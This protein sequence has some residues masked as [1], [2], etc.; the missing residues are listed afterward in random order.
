[1]KLIMMLAFAGALFACN[2]PANNGTTAKDS[3]EHSDSDAATTKE[4]KWVPVDSAAAMKAWM[5]F[6]TPGPVHKWLA[7]A[8]GEWEGEITQWMAPDA[9]PMTIKG[10]S[11][12]KTIMGGRYQVG[13]FKGSFMGQPFEGMS[14]MGYDNT[15]KM[16]VSSW[17]DNM[18]TGI[19]QME[20]P[21]DTTA[22]TITLT[23]S[24]IDP[25]TGRKCDMKEVYT[26]T[27]KDHQTME[28]FGPDP[29]TGKP[30]K[31]ME[32]KF[33]RKK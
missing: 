13:N 18:G 5:D 21:V 20:G 11:S 4:E 29:K 12:N 30:Y 25:A 2:N 16:I 10:S 24:M 1:M 14:T 22:K 27:D 6:A 33:T 3:A 23:G 28:M 31:S 15:K 17:L 19:M 7:A 8:D 9:P 32:I 26:F